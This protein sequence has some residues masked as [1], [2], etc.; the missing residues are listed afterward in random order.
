MYDLNDYQTAMVRTYKPER[1]QNHILGLIGEA[2]ESGMPIEALRKI[3]HLAEL[4][5][6][7]I[8]H[9][10]P[11]DRDVMKDELGDVLWYLTA[12]AEDHSLTLNEIAEHNVGKLMKRY[13]QGFVHGGGIR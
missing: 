3:A 2:G 13:P 5:K 10:K 7:E 11:Y 12:M 1:L 8:Y 6:K 9:S 4:I